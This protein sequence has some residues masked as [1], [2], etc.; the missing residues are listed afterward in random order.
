MRILV[1]GGA[2]F[3][4]SNFIGQSLSQGHEIINVDKLTYA[5]NPENL[6]SD[7]N[8]KNHMFYKEDICNKQAIEEILFRERPDVIL[9]MAAESHVDRSIDCADDFIQTNVVGTH[10][11]LDASLKY[12]KSLTNKNKFRFLHLSTDEVFGA[13]NE[14]GKFNETTPY[15][16]NSP[17]AASKAASDLLVRSYY[18]TYGLPTMIVNSSNN[19]GPKQYPEKLIPLMIL[20]ALEQKPL[21]VY[22]KGQQIRDWL[23]VTDHVD[24][25]L[26]LISLGENGESYCIG[27]HN[28]MTNLSLVQ[29]ICNYLDE[30]HPVQ[31]SYQNLITFVSDRPGHDYR[32]ATDA[33][34]LAKTT[35]WSPKVGFQEGLKQTI[36]WY[37][38]RFDVLR[39]KS[40]ARKR[41]GLG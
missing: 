31:S 39:V 19:Y 33:S 32:Y 7:Y 27:A 12:Y 35:G 17:Y 5:G 28:E 16:P 6:G 23:F 38:E 41:I 26:K 40:E 1:T 2:G 30:I 13:L 10:Q 25:L 29:L 4:G 37:L 9:H 8:H 15:C 18:Q 36:L 21:P 22:G 11:L 24:A 20:N 34:K 3:I 14:T